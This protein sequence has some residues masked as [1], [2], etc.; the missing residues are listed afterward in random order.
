MPSTRRPLTCA[1]ALTTLVAA[2]ALSG[3]SSEAAPEASATPSSASATSSAPT[4]AS[5]SG[6]ASPAI[7]PTA[8]ATFGSS[9]VEQ[10]M[11]WFLGQMNDAPV[12]NN[13]A[14]HFDQTFL[15]QMPP[16]QLL[17][18]FGELRQQAPWVAESVTAKGSSGEASVVGA[19]RR[20]TLTM[21]VDEAGLIS[22]ALLRASAAGTK[23]TD[24][25]GVQ[26]R[27]ALGAPQVSIL[28]ADV[29]ASG[30]LK[31]V[32]RSGDQGVLP[33]ASMFK[34]YVLAAV[35]DEVKAGRL[36]WDRQLTLTAADKSLPSGD[37]QNKPDGT[38]VSVK[39]AAAAMISISD[40]TATDL[41]IRTVGEKA[42]LAA[43]KAADDTHLAGLTPL[44]T[45]RQM[46]WL[47]WDES[48]AA[49]KA[50]AQWKTASAAQRRTLLAAIAM[51]TP[52]PASADTAKAH[53]PQGVGWF[54]TP[55]DI[56]RAHLH[57]QTLARTPAGAPVRDILAKNGGVEVKGWEYQ[58]YKGG[59]D[60]GVIGLSLYGEAGTGASARKQVLVMIG[61]GT[62]PVD[63]ATFVAAT[64]DGADLL[65][66]TK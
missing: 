61:R 48:P 3:C 34:L 50:R 2:T 52:G 66:G 9:P 7:T 12:D 8:R 6:S 13:P 38:K 37:L 42:V 25:A 11:S 20:F 63:E 35:V 40:N 16:A 49:T 23:A 45:T 59:S 31:V 21:T 27:A 26:K 44:L 29:D 28:A 53:W 56:A 51:P 32:H 33:L 17:V 43:A 4:A 60:V 57:L 14:Q 39:D 64:Q 15:T 36:S 54:A 5:P 24:W 1:L 65:A 22:G 55:E 19:G 41:L 47:A 46:F 10:K 62:G 30:G 18:M 58:A